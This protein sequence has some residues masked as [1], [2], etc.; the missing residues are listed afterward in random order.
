MN[1]ILKN[2]IFKH[3]ISCYSI[4][5]LLFNNIKLLNENASK[6]L[7]LSGIK[8]DTDIICYKIINCG[9]LIMIDRILL[10]RECDII[11]FKKEYFKLKE[12]NINLKIRYVTRIYT[13]DHKIRIKHKKKSFRKY[14][15]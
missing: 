3:A 1:N 13:V 2:K 5:E 15:L 8:V 7:E 6:M 4:D 11:N 9:D 12:K 14:L 10:V